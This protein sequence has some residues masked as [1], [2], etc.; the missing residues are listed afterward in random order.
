MLPQQFDKR[1]RRFRS[2]YGTFNEPRLA[3]TGSGGGETS[4]TKCLTFQQRGSW[5]LF[6]FAAGT[7]CKNKKQM[8]LNIELL[9]DE[10]YTLN[11]FSCLLNH[12]KMNQTHQI[13]DEWDLVQG[14]FVEN[15]FH[16]FNVVVVL[17]CSHVSFVL[18]HKISRFGRCNQIWREAN[19]S[20]MERPLTSD[21]QLSAAV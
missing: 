3:V 4:R 14:Q 21:L 15:T 1:H 18:T 7:P 19:R 17:T 8:R 12:R 6:L 10:F 2:V 20:H 11:V 5:S 9:S 13:L 16:C